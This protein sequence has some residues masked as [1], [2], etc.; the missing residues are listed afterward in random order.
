MESSIA[1]SELA[2]DRLEEFKSETVT[3]HRHST[4]F[5]LLSYLLSFSTVYVLPRRRLLL[6]LLLFLLLLFSLSLSFPSFQHLPS[7][8]FLAPFSF[9]GRRFVSSTPSSRFRLSSVCVPLLFVSRPPSRTPLGRL[10]IVTRK[11]TRGA[12]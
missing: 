3:I 10:V 12:Q 2:S 5:P 4:R 1:G 9:S 8:S 11:G 7:S 6:L